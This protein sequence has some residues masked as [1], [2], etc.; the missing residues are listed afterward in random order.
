[1]SKLFRDVAGENLCPQGSVVCIGAFDG[2][3]RGHQALVGHARLRARELGVPAVALSFEPLPREYFARGERPARLTLP[4]AKFEGLRALGMDHVGLLR[5]NA[6]LSSMSPADFVERI[7]VRRLSAREVWVGPEFRYGKA[8]AGDLA[9]L[10]TAGERLGFRA[11]EIAPVFVAGE[12]VSSSR[13]REQLAAGDLDGVAEGLG[14]RYAIDGKVVHGRELGRRLGF[15]TANLRLQ[16][17]RAAL[18][19]IFATWVHGVE[20]GAHASV[21]SLGTRPTVFGTEPLLEAHLFDF[22][23]DLYGRRLRVEFVSKLRDEEKFAD[24]PALVRQMNIDA[25]QARKV[26]RNDRTPI[27]SLA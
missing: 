26:L 17:K 18:T 27:R 16:G 8:R 20:K 2:L 1:M 25:E 24:L 11:G 15:P 12:R 5:F 4:R 22:D 7:L 19:G 21:S 10:Q 13:L 6:A 9:H 3:H 14:R 23:G